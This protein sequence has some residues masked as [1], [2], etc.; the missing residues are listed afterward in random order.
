MHI[1]RL[2]SDATVLVIV[3]SILGAFQ[4]IRNTSYLILYICTKQLILSLDPLLRILLKP[5]KIV[6]FL[7][8]DSG[9]SNT[10]IGNLIHFSGCW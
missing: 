4:I 10:K 7:I 2:A 5:P 6:L 1:L 3:E 9:I 8:G